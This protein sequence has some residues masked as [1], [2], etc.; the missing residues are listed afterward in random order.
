AS[1]GPPHNVTLEPPPA[2][3]T[4]VTPPPAPPPSPPARVPW[5][6]LVPA[7]IFAAALVV[8]AVAIVLFTNGDENRSG[9]GGPG[10]SSSAP[11]TSQSGQTS[12]PGGYTPYKGSSFTA[13]APEGWKAEPE[14]DDVT[15]TDQTKGVVRGLAIQRLG[16]SFQ[17]PGDGLA[18]AIGQMKNDP[19]YPDF[20]QESFDRNVPYKYGPAAELQFTFTKNGTPSRAKVRVFRSGGV[21]YQ[22]L[23]VTDRAHWDESVTYYETFLQSLTMTG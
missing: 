6:L 22:V 13:A 17:S 21:F 18:S 11:S 23:L 12:V 16:T 5:A 9:K 7:G 2:G 1:A 3:P 20:T 14:G 4:V 15:F 8:A 10:T 19:G